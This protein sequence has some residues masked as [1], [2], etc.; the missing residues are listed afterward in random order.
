MIGWNIHRRDSLQLTVFVAVIFLASACLRPVMG[1][2]PLSLTNHK[3]GI[4]VSLSG[5]NGADWAVEMTYH[6]EEIADQILYVKSSVNFSLA[7]N[8]NNTLAIDSTSKIARVLGTIVPAG[9]SNGGEIRYKI[10]RDQQAHAYCG[11]SAKL[12][13]F[14][15]AYAAPFNFDMLTYSDAAR[16]RVLG[17][18]GD[19]G[20][21]YGRSP[22]ATKDRFCYGLRDAFGNEWHV[23]TYWDNDVPLCAALGVD[24]G[25]A[26]GSDGYCVPVCV[27]PQTPII[28]FFGA[29]AAQF[30]TT[31]LKTYH[32]PKIWD[33]TT[34]LTAGVQ[35]SFVNLTNRDA[36]MYCVD[37]GV[38]QSWSGAPLNAEA[39]FSGE[40]STHVLEARC[41][42]SGAVLRRAIVFNPG[43]PAPAEHHGNMLWADEAERQALIYKLNN[44]QP[45][46]ISYQNCFR[47]DNWIQGLPASF[48]DQRGVWRYW[49]GVVGNAL[50]NALVLAVEGPATP[51][52]SA[53][54]PALKQRLLWM[55]RLE[56][57]GFECTIDDTTPAKDYLSELGQT[58][59]AWVDAAIA[60]DIAAGFYRSAQHPGGLT[61]IEEM[62]V[63]DG[64]AKV[65]KSL[66]QFRD[67]YSATNGSGDTHYALGYELSLAAIALAM[68]TYK[69]PYYGVSGG[70]RQTVNDLKDDNGKYW[71][72][73]PE[74][75]A[76]WYAAATDPWIARPGYP[77][78]VYS[79]RSDY[80][81]T[82]DG[83]WS[84]ANDLIG[85]P[86]DSGGGS[87]RYVAGP[88]G[89]GL[90]DIH[91]QG[92]ANAECRV[93]MQ[94]MNGYESPFVERIAVLDFIRR[95]KGDTTQAVCVTNYL[96]R[97]LTHGVVTL[98][99]N[100]AAKTY[101]PDAP[102]VETAVYCFNRHYEF[103]SLPGPAAL[104]SRFL[105]DLKAYYGLGGAIDQ[106]TH[107]RIYENTRKIFY[108]PYGLALCEDPAT[109]PAHAPEPNHPPIVKPLFKYVVKPGEPCVKYVL[110]CDP[111]CLP[112]TVTVSGLPE[113]A[114]WD[115]QNRVIKWTPTAK[116]AG[117]HIVTVAASDGKAA[118]TR[119]FA[120]IVKADA[121]SGRIPPAPANVT[122]AMTSDNS[123]VALNWVKPAG[124]A[125]AAYAIYRDGILWAAT[126]GN[127]TTWTDSELILP[128]S[129]TRYNVS[130]WAM[131][132]AESN[133][134]DATPDILQVPAAGNADK[135]SGQ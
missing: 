35:L 98:T 38:W 62:L 77:N 48:T 117:V 107:D 55:S 120:M 53:V 86:R 60:Y 123:A 21:S 91:Y 9:A 79:F 63:R 25:R 15:V 6:D 135:H 4:S 46:K 43:Y 20:V 61:P 73:F 23:L 80:E 105:N 2:T 131:N 97:R 84:G 114:I 34:Y 125:V 19:N 104:V 132:G 39:L 76:T 54:A 5:V 95:I 94:E 1:A 69:T 37:G 83:W 42:A 93:E 11:P 64:L 78:N 115:A 14:A 12:P 68:P 8:A 56:P 30:Y 18:I 36:V 29:G 28:Q 3:S 81:I 13:P 122:A 85:A 96:R 130:L 112:L 88:N 10:D 49:P 70:D 33:R 32:I 75:G 106:A 126:P 124:V 31:P 134:S 26:E 111:D 89:R 65:A 7:H 51:A 57:I 133:A 118:T 67:N 24:G 71:N 109:L 74:Q 27:N 121:G 110:A 47:S 101:T 45:F 92:M 103:A 82:D 87:D 52:G 16:T 59:E 108:G 100:P 90:V 99:W 40:N 58:E 128:S 102:R 72:P 116:D 44:V 127:V 129:K 113:G 17:K 66:L 119:P 50:S 22:L 41:G